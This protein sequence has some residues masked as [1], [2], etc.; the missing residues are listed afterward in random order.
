MAYALSGV[1]MASPFSGCASV[2]LASRHFPR[3]ALAAAI[4]AGLPDASLAQTV[5]PEVRVTPERGA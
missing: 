4:L 3:A 2:A 5:L 1:E